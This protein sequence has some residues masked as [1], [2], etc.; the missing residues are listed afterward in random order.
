M[1]FQM[2]R[3]VQC[4]A[5]GLVL[6][7][8]AALAQVPEPSPAPEAMVPADEMIRTLPDAEVA[9]R[10]LEKM[11]PENTRL[12]ISLSR[13]LAWLMAG[14]EVAVKT[15]ISSGKRRGLT[16][17]GSYTILQKEPEHRSTIYGDFVDAQGRVVRAGISLKIDSAPSGTHFVGAPMRW[18]L[19]FDGALGLHLGMLPGYPASH[20]CVRLPE[21][22]AP[23][24]YGKVS[25][26]TPVE[27]VE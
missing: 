24:I 27:V 25:V 4:F 17:P 15:P 1:T 3:I 7:A 16:P 5:A 19:R 9:P 23:L 6:I 10:V 21:A 2:R 13:Q 8:P 22:I 18:F 14:E 26:G 12:R 11:K 20:G